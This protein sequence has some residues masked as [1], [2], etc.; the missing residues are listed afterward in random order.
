MNE[1]L[2]FLTRSLSS[3]FRTLFVHSFVNE[4]P[5]QVFFIFL[6]AFLDRKGDTIVRSI[7]VDMARALASNNH[8]VF[9]YDYFGTGDS[10]GAS[11]EMDM[12]D[13]I[14]DLKYIISYVREK[15][16]PVKVV[17]FGVRLGANIALKIAESDNELDNLIIIEPV[18]NGKYFYRSRLLLMKTAHILYDV[19]SDFRITIDGSNY[20]NFD[21]IP[22]S[23]HLKNQLLELKPDTYKCSGKNILFYSFNEKEGADLKLD[24]IEG[25]SIDKLKTSLDFQNRVKFSTILIEEQ[26]K[27]LILSEQIVPDVLKFAQ[28]IKK[29][30]LS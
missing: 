16:N 24:I 27:N 17:L 6:N 19:Q 2:F 1:N 26:E 22:V 11:Y 18:A 7:Q 12:E 25:N 23:Q 3:G 15:F 8:S 13:A 14:D 28:L 9:H 30:T 21:G 20:E 10:H 29:S 5:D 4:T